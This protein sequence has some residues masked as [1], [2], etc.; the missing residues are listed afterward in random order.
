MALRTMSE[1]RKL[2]YHFFPTIDVILMY[3]KEKATGN[4]FPALCPIVEKDLYGDHA[5]PWVILKE[6]KDDANN[7]WD[8]EVAD[9]YFPNLPDPR[10]DSRVIYVITR[11][12]N[13]AA[14]NGGNNNNNKV[15]AAGCG[16]WHETSQPKFVKNKDGVI[17]GTMRT[18]E[19][20]SGSA[21]TTTVDRWVMEEYGL[22]GV[23]LSPGVSTDYVICEITKS[24]P[25]KAEGGGSPPFSRSKL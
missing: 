15:M 2:G 19:F 17:I 1:V 8:S 11:V 13:A 9:K 14:G 3:L 18:L 5:T 7:P 16:A 25:K 23:L 10:L 20:K 4:P 21:E 12:P 6:D 22:A 24:T